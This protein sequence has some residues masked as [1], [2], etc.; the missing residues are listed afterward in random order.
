MSRRT[1][2]LALVGVTLI[3]LVG[4]V[5][6]AVLLNPPRRWFPADLTR[7]VVVDNR[8]MGSVTTPDGGVAAARA[9]VTAWNSSGV[10]IVSSSSGAPNIA[11][12]D[13]QSHLVFTDPLNIC[14]GQCLAATTIGYYS[15]GQT[16]TCDGLQLVRI[17]DSDIVFNTRYDYTTVDEGG[18]SGEIFLES[19]VTHEVGH[20]IGLAH[21]QNSSALMAPTVAYCDN[22]M[23][24]SDDL[25]GRN[26]LYDCTFDTGGGGGGGGGGGCDN[27]GVCESGENCTNCSDCEGRQN[28][29]PADRFCC[30]D[31]TQQSAEGNGAICDGNF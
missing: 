21:S 26:A 4:T 5:A 31:G 30:G 9:A 29:R 3:L 6:A 15:T 22:K 13:G 18:C 16:G 1:L 23:I 17:T 12:G 25:A 2:R 7:N 27:D 20:L 28:G 8:G 11:L 10:T 24:H 14:K 19:V